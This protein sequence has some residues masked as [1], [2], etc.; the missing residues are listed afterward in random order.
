MSSFNCRQCGTVITPPDGYLQPLIKCHVCGSLE[1]RPLPSGEAPK[2]KILDDRE[3]ARLELSEKKEIIEK[4]KI[5]NE[6]Y[7]V[8]KPK[9]RIAAPVIASRKPLPGHPPA[10]AKPG[11][12]VEKAV[13]T[14]KFL[15]DALGQE[16]FEMV[17]QMVAGYLT[18]TDESKKRAK[19]ARVVQ[20]LMKAKVTAEMAVQ[21]VEYAEKS[22]KTREILWNN[23]KSG[24]V[25]GLTIFGVGVIL[26]LLVHFLSNPGRG[27]YLF[28]MPFAVGFAY[29]VNSAI[30]LAGL[31]FEKLRSEIVHYAIMTVLVLAIVF[32][33]VWGIYF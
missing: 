13:D 7:N 15:I 21:A 1:K 19:K 31:R 16:G 10:Y 18:E 12:N 17:F 32:Y 28:Q 20:N 23:Y 5:F 3:R 4:S 24:L 11:K 29:A 30:N 33:V 22:P 2:F 9:R 8:E 26:S 6:N 14:K 27:F 25:W